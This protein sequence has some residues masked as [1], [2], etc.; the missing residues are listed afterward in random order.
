MLAAVAEVMTA[1]AAVES[2]QHRQLDA[3]SRLGRVHEERTR[4]QVIANEVEARFERARLL[5]QSRASAAVEGRRGG[6]TGSNAAR[7]DNP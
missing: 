5:T 4:L 3:E 7:D 2:A 6:T 1:R